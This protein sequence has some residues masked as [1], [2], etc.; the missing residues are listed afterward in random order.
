MFHAETYHSR[1]LAALIHTEVQLIDHI[2]FLRKQFH[3]LLEEDAPI[4]RKVAPRIEAWFEQ[5][6]VGTDATA[7]KLEYFDGELQKMYADRREMELLA[8]AISA[9]H[10]DI[11]EWINEVAMLVRVIQ[12]KTGAEQRGEVPGMFW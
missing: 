6:E 5:L 11:R 12:V 8:T 10:G 3:T 4:T 7:S 1:G 9:L 2:E